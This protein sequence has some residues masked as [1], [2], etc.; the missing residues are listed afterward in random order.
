M[1]ELEESLDESIDE[2][3]NQEFDGIIDQTEFR[4]LHLILPKDQYRYIVSALKEFAK[5]EEVS[6]STA[7]EWIIAD[8]KAGK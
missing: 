3:L 1:D 7:L 5:K 2:E 6:I 8:W 4:T